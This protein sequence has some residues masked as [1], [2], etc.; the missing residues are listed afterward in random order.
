MASFAGGLASGITQGMRLGLEMD[1]RKERAKDRDITREHARLGL[2]NA[3]REQNS[4]R[5]RDRYIHE[6][7]TQP[8]LVE[9]ASGNVDAGGR[10]PKEMTLAEQIAYH[11]RIGEMDFKAGKMSQADFMALP[12]K[13]KLYEAE[14]VLAA[15]DEMERSNDGEA[16]IAAFNKLGKHKIKA[17]QPRT[18][19]D[20]ITGTPVTEFVIRTQDDKYETLN[21]LEVAREAGGI[22]GFKEMQDAHLRARAASTAERRADALELGVVQ[23]GEEAGRRLDQGDRRLSQGDRALSI[24]EV[25]GPGG[26]GGGGGSSVFQQKRSAWLAL[27][28]G[29][30]AGALDYASGRRRLGNTDLRLSAE[31]LANSLKDPVTNQPLSTA[32]K[33]RAADSI[34]ERLVAAGREGEPSPGTGEPQPKRRPLSEY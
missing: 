16:G 26:R 20:P 8:G 18:V 6:A 28:P 11:R 22:K 5:E 30:D 9:D 25:W 15:L 29:D 13:L 19:R 32:A 4:A 34:Y 17:Y 7:T 3:Q 27:H 2:E 1:E 14:G 24:R 10:V 21:P 12:Q 31:R 33:K 23:R